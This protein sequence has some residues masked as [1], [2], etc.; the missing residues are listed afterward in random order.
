MVPTGPAHRE[1]S[2]E[3]K[4]RYL[5]RH[6]RVLTGNRIV[7]DYLV[8]EA[9]AKFYLIEGRHKSDS[10]LNVALFRLFHDSV[11]ELGAYDKGRALLL[12]HTIEEFQLDEIAIILRMDIEEVQGDYELARSNASNLDSAKIL[13]IEDEAIVAMDMTQLIT[14]LG[15]EVTGVAMTSAQAVAIAQA[16]PPDLVIADI[17]LADGSSGVEAVKEIASLLHDVPAIYTTGYSDKLLT[18]RD[19]EPIFLLLKPIRD[20]QIESAILQALDVARKFPDR[21]HQSI[22]GLERFWPPKIPG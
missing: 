11:Q 13:L 5:R 9:S 3:K 15:H 4:L 12:L 8:D 10:A 16:A 14:D 22:A 18:G 19:D 21:W 1:T 7:G 20:S 2:L 6:A 17:E